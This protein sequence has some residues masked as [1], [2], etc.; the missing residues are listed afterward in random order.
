MEISKANFVSAT[1]GV[2]IQTQQSNCT[3]PPPIWFDDATQWLLATLHRGPAPRRVFVTTSS[4]WADWITVLD[5]CGELLRMSVVL[6]SKIH[7]LNIS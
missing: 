5:S 7:G 3:P 1:L 2:R 6:K 4:V